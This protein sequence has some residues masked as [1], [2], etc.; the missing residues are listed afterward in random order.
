MKMFN[1]VMN[2]L[3]AMN[4][5]ILGVILNFEQFNKVILE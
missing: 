1:Y 3:H 4:L 2:Y 5:F